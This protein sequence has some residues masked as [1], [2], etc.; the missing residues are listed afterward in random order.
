MSEQESGAPMSPEGEWS[1]CRHAEVDV[2]FDPEGKPTVGY[3]TRCGKRI[4]DEML[5]DH[6]AR[7]AFGGASRGV[8]GDI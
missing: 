4:S 8:R 6:L 3:C 2:V 5:A 7:I 1:V